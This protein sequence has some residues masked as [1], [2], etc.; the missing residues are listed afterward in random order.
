MRGEG[1]PG[2][3][4]WVLLLHTLQEGWVP[5]QVESLGKGTRGKP[6]GWGT[7]TC[8][9][10]DC[11]SG[12]HCERGWV[13]CRERGALGRV[14][15]HYTCFCPGGFSGAYSLGWAPYRVGE[16]DLLLG[17]EKEEERS[18]EEGW[19][20]SMRDLSFS[21]VFGAGLGIDRDKEQMTMQWVWRQNHCAGHHF[22]HA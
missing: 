16:G 7:T 21:L 1:S 6:E 9:C 20:G 15:I 18:R 17:G 14:S 10:P 8:Y 2:E 5:C 13:S 19:E 12:N 3:R 4:T 11:F 22:M